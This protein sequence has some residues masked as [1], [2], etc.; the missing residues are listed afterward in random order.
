MDAQPSASALV[1]TVFDQGVLRLT[2]T[3]PEKRNALSGALIAAIGEA[4]AQWAARGEVAIAVLT[5]AGDKA[6]ASGGDLKELESLRGEDAARAFATRTRAAFD[7]I[8]RF[9][10]PVVALLNGDALGGGAELALACD[11]R[12]AKAHARVGFLQARLNIAP[13]WGGGT[14]LFTLVGPSRATRLLASAEILSATEAQAQGL[15]DA[16]LPSGAGADPAFAAYLSAMTQRPQVMRAIKSLAIAHRFGAS[17]AERAE[18]E[19][20]AFAVAWVHDDHWDAVR[21]MA[22][23]DKP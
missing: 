14:D 21:R 4:F 18:R 23:R 9:P 15:V 3:R 12:V 8:R 16:V 13:A 2:L 22:S 7:Q 10:V 19:G 6:F 17:P 1:A 5:G 20:A 11:H